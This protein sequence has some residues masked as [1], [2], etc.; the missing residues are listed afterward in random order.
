M[1][2]QKDTLAPRSPGRPRDE[3]L[4]QRRRGEILDR[5]ARIFA[6]TGFRQT[7]LKV[8]AYSLG[9]AKGTLY[10]YFPSKEDLFFAAIDQGLDAL[11]EAVAASSYSVSALPVHNLD[12]RHALRCKVESVIGFFD[13]NRHIF[14]LFLQE[15]AEFRSFRGDRAAFERCR[16]IMGE[17]LSTVLL[18]ILSTS[19]SGEVLATRAEQIIDMLAPGQKDDENLV[20]V[21]KLAWK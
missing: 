7:D 16:L 13:S 6:E 3:S 15:R 10:N 5:A 9:V 8:V 19:I 17:P 2:F 11:S 18:G 21:R 1:R 20:Q 12:P 4:T 14:E